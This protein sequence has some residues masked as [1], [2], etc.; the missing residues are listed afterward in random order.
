MK[1]VLLISKHFACNFLIFESLL[2]DSIY[3]KI[4]NKIYSSILSFLLILCGNFSFGQSSVLR[5]QIAEIAKSARGIVGVS[6][7]G[8]EDRDT[9]SYNGNARLVM[10]SV[11]KFPIAMA[12]LHLVDSGVLTL[13]QTIHL[14]KKDLP[15]TYSPLRDKY[16]DGDV[17]VSIGDL[18]TYMV[19]QSDNDA[20]DILL[21]KLGG[22][23][24]VN[25]YLRM[26]KMK[27]INI[28]ASEEDMAKVPESQY[29]DWCRPK[30]M[31]HLLDTLYT[32][33]VLK[34][35]SKD[36]LIKLLNE[37]ST[38]PNR[39]KGLLPAG[40]VVGHKTGTSGTNDAGVALGTNDVGVITL[41]NGKHVAIAI[42]VINSTADE[43]TRDLVIAKI[44]KAVYDN[45]M[46]KKYK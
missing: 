6:V 20:C 24:Q 21:A 14:K 27:G 17:D 1:N 31:V 41:P 19:S 32:G 13:N 45:Q 37:T 28:Q 35:A 2:L 15:K 12:V 9:V 36:Y 29:T 39:I 18:L 25:F 4:M 34:P 16:P 43:A 5:P 3:P 22:P 10:E 26:I 30:A 38:G 7:L 33:N 42:L 44:A 23:D 8:L 40:T 46:L 11:M